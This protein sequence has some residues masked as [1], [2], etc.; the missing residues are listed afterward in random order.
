MGILADAEA[1]FSSQRVSLDQLL[2]KVRSYSGQT[3][4]AVVQQMI[5]VSSVLGKLYEGTDQWSH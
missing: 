4:Y 5:E 3:K 2:T 1:L